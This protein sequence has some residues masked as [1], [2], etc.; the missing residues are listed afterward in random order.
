[1]RLRRTLAR[2]AVAAL[3]AG[4]LIA[5]L[6]TSAA[7]DELTLRHCTNPI[8]SG[9]RVRRMDVCARGW[10]S[11]DYRYTRS[12]VEVHTYAWNGSRWVDSRSQTITMESAHTN[13]DGFIVAEWGQQKSGK[14]RVNSNT[15]RIACSV[16]S[17]YRVAFYGPLVSAP[18][19]H[20]FSTKVFYVSW[21][22]DRGVPHRQ[23]PIYDPDPGVD[24]LTSPNW[25]A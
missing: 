9:D 21:R 25:Y 19:L 22:D 1:M 3:L 16:G 13:A 12:V 15:G 7:A 8:I 23:V 4:S 18:G 17:T 5:A 20:E 11:S 14:C 24:W 6:P 2:I 10:I